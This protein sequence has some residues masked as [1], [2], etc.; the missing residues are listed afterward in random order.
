MNYDKHIAKQYI[1]SELLLLG[2]NVNKIAEMNPTLE[3]LLGLLKGIITMM[4]ISNQPDVN[5][6]VQVWKI[7]EDIDNK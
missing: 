4:I 5:G 7:L 1:Y 6:I 3:Q 2:C